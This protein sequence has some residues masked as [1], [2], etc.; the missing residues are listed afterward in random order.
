M[1]M[2][3]NKKEESKGLGCSFEPGEVAVVYLLLAVLPPLVA[4]VVGRKGIH[5]PHPLLFPASLF[6]ETNQERLT[7]NMTTHIK[8]TNKTKY[9]S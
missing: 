7:P 2:Q 3:I 5:L 1:Q 4:V 9:N 6:S 8:T